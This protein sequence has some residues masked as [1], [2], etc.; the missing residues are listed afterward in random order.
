MFWKKTQTAIH[1]PDENCFPHMDR[2]EI[3]EGNSQ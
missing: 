1:G 2:I 3:D